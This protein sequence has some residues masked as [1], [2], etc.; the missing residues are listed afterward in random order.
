[1]PVANPVVPAAILPAPV[2]LTSAP[3]F[4]PVAPAATPVMPVLPLQNL[5]AIPV[6]RVA[7]T[8]TLWVEDAS[9]GTSP[10]KAPASVMTAPITPV[11]PIAQ[12]TVEQAVATL[13]E[14][15][16]VLVQTSQTAPAIPVAEA[17]PVGRPRRRSSASMEE[18]A[19]VMVETRQ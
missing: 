13:E 17:A 8:S 6:D 1:M 15:G 19:I 5:A 14:C 16:L 3:L 18:E 9:N 12:P 2:T 4:E 7:E 10:I 11:I